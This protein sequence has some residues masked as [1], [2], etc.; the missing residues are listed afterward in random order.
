[1]TGPRRCDGLPFPVRPSTILPLC[2]DCL[3]RLTP[4][5]KSVQWITPAAH[6]VDYVWHC[7]NKVKE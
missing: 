2:R 6:A 1:M 4:P 7:P 5:G 3:L